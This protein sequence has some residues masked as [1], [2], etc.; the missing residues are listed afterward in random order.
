ML[1]LLNPTLHMQ[2]NCQAPKALV[3]L[4]FGGLYGGSEN[5]FY[6][7]ARQ[8]TPVA[9]GQISATFQAYEGEKQPIDIRE[10]RGAF[11]IH[12]PTIGWVELSIAF[13]DTIEVKKLN[14]KPLSA[15]GRLGNY[16][17]NE[18]EKMPARM[19]KAQDGVASVVECCGLD[20]KCKILNFEVIRI[21]ANNA[22]ERKSNNGGRFQEDVKQLV[23]KAK[24]GDIFIFRNIHYQCPGTSE[25]TQRMEDMIFQIE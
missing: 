20:V 7:V 19:L 8:A 25:I 23:A 4:P 9:L 5:I 18:D 6:L 11:F 21:D 13:S 14:V 10:D 22:A 24:P 15:V 16:K 12:P 1:F 2:A 3:S 17:A